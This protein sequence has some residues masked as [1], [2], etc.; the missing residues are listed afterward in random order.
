M[1]DLS[2]SIVAYKDYDDIVTAIKTLEKYTPSSIS[3]DIYIVDNSENSTP[4][5]KKEQKKFQDALSE[6]LDVHYIHNGSNVG[7]GKGHNKILSIIDSKYHCIMNPDIEF[8]EDAF[9]PIL[10][11]FDKYPDV[12]MIIPRIETPQGKL[13]LAYRKELTVFDMF[14]RMFCKRLF[15][16]R[17]KKHTL[18]DQDYSK[19]FQVPFGQGSFLVIRTELFKKLRGFDEGYFM[20]LEDADLC[21]R[22]NQVSKLMYIPDTRVVHK[23]ERGSHKNRTLFK[24]HVKS[25][26]YYFKKW[27]YKWF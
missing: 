21:R 10:K 9:T 22:V 16:K 12:G 4:E 5:E 3:K 11:Y 25:M 17:I 18:Q 7:F 14:I 27:G 15:P 24:H 6:Y 23:W 8:V 20:Y 13:Q 2:V 1:K 19:P 26:K